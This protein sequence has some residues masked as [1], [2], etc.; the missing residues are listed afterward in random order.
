MARQDVR[1]VDGG[2]AVRAADVHVLPE[3]RELLREVAVD[4]EQ[5]VEA[6]GRVDA[7]IGPLVEG[8]GAA[9]RDPDVQPPRR[10]RDGAAQALQLRRERL[11]RAVHGGVQLHHALGD[12]RLDRAGMIGFLQESDQVRGIAG[13]VEIARVQDLQL[14][15]RADRERLRAPELERLAHCALP[16]PARVTANWTAIGPA[17]SRTM[18]AESTIVESRA[19]NSG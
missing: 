7:A 6:L 17:S 8:V 13:E 15:L 5:V 4:G 3:Y 2:V 11:V 19:T 14:E 1:E 10:L 12:L 9:A 18:T 16:S